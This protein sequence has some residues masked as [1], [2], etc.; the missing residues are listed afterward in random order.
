MKAWHILFSQLVF[1]ASPYLS[2]RQERCQLPDGT[3]I[4]DYNIISE[5]DI[6]IA[7]V[8]TSDDRVVLVEQYKHG[9][10]QLCL[11]LPGGLSEGGAPLSEVQREI[12]EE[13]G[14]ESDN[15][16]LLSRYIN[17]PTRFDNHVYAFVARHAQPTTTQHLDPT[18]DITVHLWSIADVL[19]AIQDGRITALHSVATILQGLLAVGKL[20]N[21]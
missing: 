6:V 4:P 18:E 20:S 2:V 12:R 15:W 19:A 3:V 17:N 10:G 11:E 9:I 5:P 14:Y 1:D 8:L 16:L 13:T 21:H 7:L